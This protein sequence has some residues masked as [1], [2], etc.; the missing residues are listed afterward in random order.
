MKITE[1]LA[2]VEPFDALSPGALKRLAAK[3]EP[4]VSISAW[5]QIAL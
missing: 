4:D 2:T 5:A 1:F 3:V